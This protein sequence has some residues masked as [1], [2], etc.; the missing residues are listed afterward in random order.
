MLVGASYKLSLSVLL[1]EYEEEC[2]LYEYI[3]VNETVWFCDNN[4]FN[5]VL[6][7]WCQDKYTKEFKTDC[8]SGDVGCTC[9]EY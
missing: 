8:N 9:P 4:F 5:A 1:N 7:N 3:S 6:C 2:L